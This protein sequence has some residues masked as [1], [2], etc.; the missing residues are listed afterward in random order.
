ML[1]D[2]GSTVVPMAQMQNYGR[3]WYRAIP[4]KDSWYIIDGLEKEAVLSYKIWA[5]KEPS[6]GSA[7]HIHKSREFVVARLR[8]IT[9][10]MKPSEKTKLF[11]GTTKVSGQDFVGCECKYR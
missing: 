1:K 3:K 6:C 10:Q 8:N 4:W 2:G 5:V 11:Q 7:S 9:T